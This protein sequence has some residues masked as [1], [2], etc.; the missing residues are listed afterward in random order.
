MENRSSIPP[1]TVKVVGTSL[2]KIK[3]NKIPNNN[4]DSKIRLPAVALKYSK[5]LVIVN[6]A[7]KLS[8]PNIKVVIQ[9]LRER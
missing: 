5:P 1:I 8:T 2:K 7:R 9:V 3:A 4:S 6:Q